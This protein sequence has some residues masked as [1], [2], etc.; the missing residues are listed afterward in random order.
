MAQG[1]PENPTVIIF[2]FWDLFGGV[3]GRDCVFGVLPIIRFSFFNYCFPVNFA[4]EGVQFQTDQLYIHSCLVC[5]C[6]N[7]YWN[8]AIP[9]DISIS[10]SAQKCIPYSI[11]LFKNMVQKL[12]IFILSP[13]LLEAFEFL[14]DGMTLLCQ[15][16]GFYTL[17]IELHAPSNTSS[18]FLSHYRRVFHDFPH[19]YSHQVVGLPRAIQHGNE[20]SP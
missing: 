7:L 8:W 2:N 3:S 1:H 11:A 5:V 18:Q 12:H 17:V 13:F 14:Q 6:V 9:H 19:G 20:N 16:P 15:S 4:R 10:C